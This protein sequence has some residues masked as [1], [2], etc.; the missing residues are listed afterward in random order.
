M[1]RPSFAR[2]SPLL[3]ADE[4]AALERLGQLTGHRKDDVIIAEGAES[5]HALLIKQ[6]HVKVVI[7]NPARIIA[8]YGCGDIVGAVGAIGGTARR[9]ASAVAI[10]DVRVVWLPA[11]RL[12]EYVLS[13]PRVAIALMRIT[14]QRLDRLSE[15]FADSDPAAEQRFAKGLAYLVDIGLGQRTSAG[16]KLPFSLRELAGLIGGNAA[17]PVLRAVQAL[18]ATGVVRTGRAELTVVDL[19]ALRDIAGGA[20]TS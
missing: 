2:V 18:R 11:D 6:G 14:Q 20:R 8:I 4:L 3:D 10:N 7:G 5:S 9:V 1:D 17:E 19:P 13:R 12:R 16:T 15:G